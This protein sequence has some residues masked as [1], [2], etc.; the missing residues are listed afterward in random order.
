MPGFLPNTIA[1]DYK[2]VFLVETNYEF[3]D[4]Q[5][6]DGGSTNNLRRQAYWAL[7]SGATG[8]IYG[9]GP[10]MAIRE[11]LGNETR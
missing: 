2:P 10:H 4:N 11:R 9:S 6:K 3:E 7:L 1:T 8:Q 5:R